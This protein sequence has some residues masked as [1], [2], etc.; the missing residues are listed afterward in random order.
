MICSYRRSTLC[1]VSSIEDLEAQFKAAQAAAEA[2]SAE[3]TAK[4][5]EEFPQPEDWRGPDPHPETAVA[6]A[7]AWTEAESAELARLR[8]VARELAVELHRAQQAAPGHL[9]GE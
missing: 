7:R 2:Y 3:I 5:R 9:H 4:Y 6:R 8:T 1:A